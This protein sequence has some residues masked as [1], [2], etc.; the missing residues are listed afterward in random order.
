MNKKTFYNWSEH[1]YCTPQRVHEPRSEAELI[2]IMTELSR[3]DTHVRVF[4]GGLSP[5][6]IAMSNEELVLVSN[7]DG[8]LNVDSDAATVMVQ[9]GI[10]LAALSDELATY[11][12]ALPVLSSVA[13]QTVAGA[14][15][16]ATHGTGMKF[17]TLSTLVEGMRLVTPNGDVLNISTEENSELLNAVSCHLGSLGVI[18]QVTLRVCSAFDLEVTERPD[19]LEVVLDNL[20]ER[21]R[22]D[23]YRFWYI[24]HTDCVWEWTAIRTLPK[25]TEKSTPWQRLGI[26][27]NGRIVDYHVYESLLHLATYRPSLISIINKLGARARFNKPRY[28]RGP[29]FSQ[30]TFDCLFKQ[31]VNEWSIPIEYTAEALRGIR[32]LIARKGHYAHLPIE[33]RFVGG[34]D[35]WLSPCQGQDGCY[36]GVIAYIPHG[37]PPHH[38]AYFADFEELMETFGGRPHWGKFFKFD[39]ERLAKRYPHWEDFQQVRRRLDPDY[40][41]RNTFTDRVFHT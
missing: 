2:D 21:L 40:R 32:D 26:W 5:G 27:F 33:V 11:G 28:S 9:P 22:S 6:D 16:T 15:G 3:S 20:P 38:E 13:D 25:R 23:H 36:I 17:G 41:L 37:R 29:S 19:T 4:G 8:V 14:I 34:D 12:L 39:S 31:H 35:I 1:F 24:P 10:T 7:F 30:F 18:T